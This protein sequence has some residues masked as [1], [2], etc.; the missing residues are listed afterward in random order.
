MNKLPG[1]KLGVSVAKHDVTSG[2]CVWDA[3]GIRAAHHVIWK[4]SFGVVP[5]G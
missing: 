5:N 3:F 1:L 2:Q 4:M